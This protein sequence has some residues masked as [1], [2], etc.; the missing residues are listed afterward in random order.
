MVLPPPQGVGAQLRFTRTANAGGLL[1]LDGMA[2]L[3]DGICGGV[4]PYLPTSPA[5]LEE[6]VTDQA[7]RIIAAQGP[8]LSLADC[9]EAHRCWVPGR[10]RR[11][12]PPGR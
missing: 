1:E 6:L 9:L 10:W 3:L 2:V 11:L 12:C 5:L 8:A 4:G 7:E